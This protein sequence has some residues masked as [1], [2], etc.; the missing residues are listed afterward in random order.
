MSLGFPNAGVGLGRLFGSL[1][2]D[3]AINDEPADEFGGIE[4]A[5]VHEELAEVVAH[6]ADLG[7]IGRAKVE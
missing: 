5:S 2:Q 3:E 6:V 1:G 4:H 7:G